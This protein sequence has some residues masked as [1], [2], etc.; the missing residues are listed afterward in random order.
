[1]EEACLLHSGGTVCIANLGGSM[2]TQQR[3]MASGGS[4]PNVAQVFYLR[5]ICFIYGNYGGIQSPCVLSLSLNRPKLK[6][7]LFLVE[8]ILGLKIRFISKIKFSSIHLTTFCLSIQLYNKKLQQFQV[9][10][11]RKKLFNY[12]FNYFVMLRLIQYFCIV[13]K[14]NITNWDTKIRRLKTSKANLGIKNVHTIQL[15]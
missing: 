8:S 15:D 11:K 2:S 12:K 14:P 7:D 13:Q 1:M 6:I 10:I 9:K 5:L 3:L 4:H